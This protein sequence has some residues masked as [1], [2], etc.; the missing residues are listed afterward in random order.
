M[1]KAEP[2]SQTDWKFAVRIK[3]NLDVFNF[4]SRTFVAKG[5]IPAQ[6]VHNVEFFAKP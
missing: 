1:A 6:K 4:L 5:H 2:V 3:S